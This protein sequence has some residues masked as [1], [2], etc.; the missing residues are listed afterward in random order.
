METPP[1]ATPPSEHVVIGRRYKHA[2]HDS[3]MYDAI[4][5][6]RDQWLVL[7]PGELVP[8]VAQSRRPNLVVL[9]PWLDPTLTTVEVR[10]ENIGP[11]GGAG[12]A[13]T[14]LG[15]ASQ[16]ELLPEERKRIR[17]RLGVV[18]GEQL[19]GWVDH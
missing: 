11:N 6:E 13:L 18:F 5:D 19:R 15:Y 3:I 8:E 1:M 2:P 12:S 14:V 17:H 10:I 4:V 7:R 16:D 9:R